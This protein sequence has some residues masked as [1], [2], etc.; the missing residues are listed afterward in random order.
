MQQDYPQS[1][2]EFQ[3]MQQ[4]EEQVLASE[5]AALNLQQHEAKRVKIELQQQREQQERQIEQMN[6]QQISEIARRMEQ[7]QREIAQIREQHEIN[8]AHKKAPRT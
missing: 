8:L 7:Q 3:R 5:R 2:G 1:A 4:Q 6:A